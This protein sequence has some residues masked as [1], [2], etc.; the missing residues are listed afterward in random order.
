M[1]TICDNPMGEHL[2][3]DGRMNTSVHNWTGNSDSILNDPSAAQRI[4]TSIGECRSSVR[5]LPS[6]PLRAE[7]AINVGILRCETIDTYHPAKMPLSTGRRFIHTELKMQDLTK[8]LDTCGPGVSS[9][10]LGMRHRKRRI[11]ETMLG[12][13]GITED[14]HNT[15]SSHNLHISRDANKKT[16]L[17]NVQQLLPSDGFLPFDDRCFA[18]VATESNRKRDTSATT[19]PILQ[20]DYVEAGHTIFA[21]EADE[22]NLNRARRNVTSSRLGS[23]GPLAHQESANIR[24]VSSTLPSRHDSA[25]VDRRELPVHIS[26]ESTRPE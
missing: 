22:K 6:A 5:A 14:G 7:A 21:S 19:A 2:E 10:Q 4:D 17:S 12:S 23:S 18:T 11:S 25:C 1:E 16:S 20:T 15:M 26:H 8:Q 24:S 3:L 13:K 9:H